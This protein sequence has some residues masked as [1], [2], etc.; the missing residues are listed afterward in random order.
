MFMSLKLRK[1]M[2]RTTKK[3]MR[4]PV[5]LTNRRAVNFLGSPRKNSR[6]QKNDAHTILPLLLSPS[7]SGRSIPHERRVYGVRSLN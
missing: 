7:H 5:K 2:E 6:K 1:K 3:L 4:K